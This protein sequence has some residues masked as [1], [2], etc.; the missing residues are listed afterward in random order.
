MKKYLLFLSLIL[1]LSCKEE[2]GVGVD[3]SL[4]P[5]NE[6]QE[7]VHDLSLLFNKKQ[8]NILTRTIT[9]Y[10]ERTT[11]EIAV[12]TVDSI[13]P[14]ED[15]HL[16]ASA[17]GNYWGIGKENKDNGLLILL[18]HKQKRVWLS[19]GDGIT[20][21]LTDPICQEIIDN[22]MIPYFQ[23]GDYYGGIAEGLEEIMTIWN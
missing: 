7:V 16:F 12:L 14:F 15:I 2:Q 11:N 5:Q 18:L 6:N 1:L 10:E 3:Y 23:K 9:D 17:V 19:T 4:L 13:A 21:V 20:T 22:H 8:R